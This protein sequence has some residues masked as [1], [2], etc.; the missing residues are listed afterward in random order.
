TDSVAF[1]IETLNDY[2]MMSSAVALAV[3]LGLMGLGEFIQNLI[4]EHPN[5]SADVCTH[6]SDAK[7]ARMSVLA[8]YPAVLICEFQV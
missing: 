6:P 3:F 2:P 1:T 8:R 4:A 5:H 7:S